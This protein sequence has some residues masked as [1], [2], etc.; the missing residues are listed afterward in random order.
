MVSHRKLCISTLTGLNT[1]KDEAPAPSEAGIV[2]A[3]EE[4]A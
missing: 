4:K 1:A 2:T 3:I